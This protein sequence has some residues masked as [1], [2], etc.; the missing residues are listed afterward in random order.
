[1]R[2]WSAIFLSILLVLSLSACGQADKD[3][4]TGNR[5]SQVSAEKN[6]N[7]TGSTSAIPVS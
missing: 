4:E 3:N 1:M 6:K 5:N 2:K 7:N